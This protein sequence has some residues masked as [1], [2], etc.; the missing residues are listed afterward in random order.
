MHGALGIRD[1]ALLLIGFFGGFRR[2]ELVA[3]DLEHLE[4]RRSK[5]AILI[6][7]SKTD[8]DGVGR[9]VTIP[10]LASSLC[11]VGALERWLKLRGISAGP[12]FAAITSHGTVTRKRLSGFAVATIVK[13]RVAQIGLDAAQYSGHSLRSGFATA[14]ARAGA[15]TWQIKQQTGHKSDAVVAGYIR[16]GASTGANLARLIGR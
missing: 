16:V 5:L 7:R 13:R 10:R 9:T 2:S 8:Q 14:A 3:L 11:A 12:L 6:R 1:R 15:A 4:L